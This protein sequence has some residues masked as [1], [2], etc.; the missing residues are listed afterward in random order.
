[1]TYCGFG[2]SIL[3]LGYFHFRVVSFRYEALID[4][5]NQSFKAALNKASG[6]ILRIRFL[7]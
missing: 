4:L 5:I 1:M 6:L 2:P 7:M 3:L